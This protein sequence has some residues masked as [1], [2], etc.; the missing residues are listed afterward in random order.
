MTAPYYRPLIGF[1]KTWTKGTSGLKSAEL[2]LIDATDSATLEAYRGK[3]KNKIIIVLKKT[4]SG[5][6]L[7]LMPKDIQMKS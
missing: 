6:H 4:A 7:S 5:H 3:L 2:I 1:P